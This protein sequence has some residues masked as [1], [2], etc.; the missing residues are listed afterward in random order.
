MA[1]LVQ[2]RKEHIA[3]NFHV[4]NFRLNTFLEVGL[5]RF[6]IED[7]ATKVLLRIFVNPLC[8]HF[9]CVSHFFFFTSEQKSGN[10]QTE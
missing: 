3:L 2:M 1:N 6:S 8:I 10:I 4:C 5:F 9:W 7:H